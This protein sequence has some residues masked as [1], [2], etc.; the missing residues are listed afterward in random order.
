MITKYYVDLPTQLPVHPVKV[1]EHLIDNLIGEGNWVQNG[2]VWEAFGPHSWQSKKCDL[3][4]EELEYY[5]AL[6]TVKTYLEKNS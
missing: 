5:N 1:I 3:P 6:Q 2:E 4:A